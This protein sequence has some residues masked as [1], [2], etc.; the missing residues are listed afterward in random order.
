MKYPITPQYLESQPEA[1][2]ELYRRLEAFILNDI[3]SRFETSGE[4]TQTALELIRQLQRRGYD[5]SAVEKYIRQTLRLTE[6]EY[7][8][9]FDRA[10]GRNQAYYSD[11][12]TKSGLISM[13]FDDV[14]MIEELMALRRQT[15]DELVNITRS[16]GFAMRGP[17]GKVVFTPL[18]DVYQRVLDDAAIRVWSGAESYQSAIYEATDALTES[19]LQWVDYASGHHNR[20]DVAAR[21]AVMTGIT[22][23]SGQY[24]NFCAERVPTQYWEIT[25]HAGA[26]DKDG[27]T[28]WANHKSWQGKVYSEHAGDIYPSIY[29]VCGYGEV[30]GLMGANCRHIRHPFWEGI[31]ERTY[32]DEELANIDPPP[33]EFEG[34][35]YTAYEATQKQRQIE[36]AMRK[37]RRDLIRDKAAGL[38]DKFTAHSVRYRRLNEEYEKFSKAAGLPTQRERMRVAGFDSKLAREATRAAKKAI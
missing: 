20:V 17:D 2:A 21:R 3:C 4:A 9:I 29:E 24:A 8:E 23:I 28:P 14:A 11:V 18:A 31:S 7:N 36:T 32:T 10:V 34:R 6:A 16:M 30:D 37:T 19:G 15:Q 5:M 1:V 33:F 27:P 12:L 22:Q 26:R 38:D 35:K 25:A 13:P